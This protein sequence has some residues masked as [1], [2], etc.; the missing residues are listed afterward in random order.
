M[1]CDNCKH[2][3]ICKFIEDA[4]EMQERLDDIET[5]RPLSVGL[6]C[7]DYLEKWKTV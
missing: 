6:K 7:D 1:I 5:G 4:N 3:E 2:K